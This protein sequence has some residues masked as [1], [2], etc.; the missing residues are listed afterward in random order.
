MLD[1]LQLVVSVRAVFSLSLVFQDQPA[2]TTASFI[3]QYNLTIQL[4]ILQT[5]HFT[6]RLSCYTWILLMNDAWKQLTN[7]KNGPSLNCVKV[8]R[9]HKEKNQERD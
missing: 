7:R 3:L 6:E 8:G 1:V 9:Y 4:F 5:L 2:N